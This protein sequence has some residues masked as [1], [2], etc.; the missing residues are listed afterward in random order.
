MY[1]PERVETI[2]LYSGGRVGVKLEGDT[3]SRPDRIL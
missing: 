1:P 2:Y 3:V